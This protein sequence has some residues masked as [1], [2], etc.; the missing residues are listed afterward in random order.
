LKLGTGKIDQSQ[1]V[2]EGENGRQALETE[3]GNGEKFQGP[4]VEEGPAGLGG[5]LAR[6]MQARKKEK[7]NSKRKSGEGAS[8]GPNWK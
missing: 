7:K 1:R 3:P 6:R 8:G 4:F 5:G 2:G